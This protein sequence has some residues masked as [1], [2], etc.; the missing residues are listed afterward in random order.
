MTMAMIPMK[1]TGCLDCEEPTVDLTFDEPAL[2]IH[3]GHGATRR[4]I[5]RLC[6]ACGYARTLEVSEVRP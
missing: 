4:S 3:G 5:L 6:P 2:F 1:E